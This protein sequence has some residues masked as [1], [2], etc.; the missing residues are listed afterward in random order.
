MDILGDYEV[1]KLREKNQKISEIKVTNAVIY[2][3]AV[4][5][6]SGRPLSE[7]KALK[8]SYTR[9]LSSSLELFFEHNTDNSMNCTVSSCYSCY[10]FS[11]R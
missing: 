4:F 9:F 3:E 7:A 6:C 2:P 11:F 5:M 10:T 1:I 8:D